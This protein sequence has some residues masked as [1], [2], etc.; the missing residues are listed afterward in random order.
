MVSLAWNFSAGD[1]FDKRNKRVKDGC[2]LE[3]KKIRAFRLEPNPNY[4]GIFSIDGEEY[5]AQK[6]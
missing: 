2:K 6:M 4:P 1:H 3:Y 5:P